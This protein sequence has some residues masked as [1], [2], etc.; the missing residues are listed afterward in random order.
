MDFDWQLVLIL[1]AVGVG[2][3]GILPPRFRQWAVLLLSI[4]ALYLFQPFL[5]IRFSGYLLPTLTLALTIYSWRLTATTPP[6]RHDWITLLV[7]AGCV[8]AISSF[9]L[10]PTHLSPLVNRPP[11]LVTVALVL[12][13]LGL[14][15]LLATRINS[16]AFLTIW[17]VS[18]ILLFVVLKTEPLATEASRFWRSLTGQDR[19]LASMAD[20]NWLGFSYV[21]FRLIHTIREKQERRIP[22]LTLHQY[23][24]YTLF[25]PA[26]IAGP[27]DR[28]ERFLTDYHALPQLRGLD[29]VR[30][31][32]GLTRISLGIFKKFVIADSLAQGLSLT[33][34]LASQA[35]SSFG[36]WLLLYGY[37]FRLYFD[38]SGYSDIAIGIG[39]LFGIHLPENFNQPYL[40]TNI[41]TFW[42]SWHIT[43]SQW[44]RFYLFTPLSRWLLRRQPQPSSVLILLFAHLSTMIVIGLWHGVRW[45]FLIWGIWHGIAL[46]IHKQWSD[47]TRA[48]YRQLRQHPHRQRAWQLFSWFLTF[49]YVVLGWVWFLL[50]T[51][52][53]AIRIFL[54]L[55]E[56]G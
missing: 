46:F 34:T 31:H 24:T 17:L 12:G 20:L 40:K 25:F 14:F 7:V 41:T 53:L 4:F 49:H 48:W 21:A 44:L 3:A 33:P 22:T 1:G 2:Y 10:L 8:V 13:V 5:P 50:P 36:L 55:L 9:R 45:N 18:L 54:K 28:A 47:H 35:N 32:D 39:K 26:L 11:N 6:Q 37:A 19:S 23:L 42:Q 16:K 29:P 27:I 15:C 56:T 52:A 43:L 51:P 30:F 38:F